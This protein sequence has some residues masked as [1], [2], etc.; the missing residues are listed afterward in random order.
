[1][2]Y[3]PEL[4]RYRVYRVDAGEPV[5]LARTSRDGLGMTLVALREEGEFTT[6]DAVGILDRLDDDR[7][8]RWIVNPYGGRASG[9]HRRT[10]LPD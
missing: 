6:D 10:R 4:S 7:P 9:G 5:E 1:M 2:P 8:G 3:D